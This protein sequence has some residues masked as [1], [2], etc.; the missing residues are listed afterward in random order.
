MPPPLAELDN[1]AGKRA[2]TMAQ[3]N[4]APVSQLR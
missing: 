3:V 2:I 4:M 1:E